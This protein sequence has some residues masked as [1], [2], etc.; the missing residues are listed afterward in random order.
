MLHYCCVYS[1]GALKKRYVAAFL[2]LIAGLSS[3]FAAEPLKGIS[4][5]RVSNYGA[6]SVLLKE[7]AQVAEIVGELNSLRGKPWVHGDRRLACYSTIVFMAGTKTVAMFR[8]TPEYV[9]EQPVEKGQSRSALAIGETDLPAL[10]KVL[11]QDTPAA[12]CR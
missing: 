10:R 5:I 4:S 11:A 12:K 2:V 6:P 7:R 1:G 9:V 8:V 3:A